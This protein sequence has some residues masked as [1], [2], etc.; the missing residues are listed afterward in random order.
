MYVVTGGFFY[1]ND[2]DVSNYIFTWGTHTID[3]PFANWKKI[4]EVEWF[5]TKYS[6][7]G[8]G[9]Y[10]AFANVWSGEYCLIV[11]SIILVC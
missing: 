6:N 9:G 11:T 7:P 5:Y 8:T 2:W 4:N 1:S 10:G 3:D